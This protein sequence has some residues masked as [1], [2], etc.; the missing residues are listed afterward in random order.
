MA[1]LENMV[2]ELQ[3]NFDSIMD[4]TNWMSEFK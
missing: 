4:N 2:K 3:D 1:K